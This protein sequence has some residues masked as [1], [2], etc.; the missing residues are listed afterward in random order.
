MEYGDGWTFE[1]VVAV[2]TGED[3]VLA[4]RAARREASGPSTA[5][6]SWRAE[7]LDARVV[8]SRCVSF[9]ADRAPEGWMPGP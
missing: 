5:T 7:T 2:R 1:T 3:R 4:L 8:D 9:G 6:P